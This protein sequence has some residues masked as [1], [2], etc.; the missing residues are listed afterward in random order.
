[1]ATVESQTDNLT[2]PS[3]QGSNTYGCPTFIVGFIVV[4]I[5]LALFFL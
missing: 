3:P 1:M 5:V 2:E 4:L